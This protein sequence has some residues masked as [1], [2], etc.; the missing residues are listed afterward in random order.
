VKNFLKISFIL[1]FCSINI[2][3]Q[4]GSIG[5]YDARSVGMGK[6]HTAISRGVFSI[7]YN[8]A[9]LAYGENNYLE[10]STLLPLPNIN[11][12]LGTDFITI[13][14]YNYFFGGV[15]DASGNTVGRYLTQAD[16]DRLFSI[17]E[18]GGSFL[19]NFSTSL[20]TASY[21]VNDEI[22]SF[23][24]S[25]CDLISM[26]VNFPEQLVE[27][28]LTGNPNGK[29]Y[30]F[31]DADAAGW[32]LRNYSFSYARSIPDINLNIFE[33]V[34]AGITIKYVQGFAYLGIDKIETSLE[35]NMF[36]EINAHGNILAY[37]S[38]ADDFNVKYDFDSLKT[39]KEGNFALF[40]SPAGKGLGIDLGLSAQLNNVWSFGFAITD[41]GSISWTK[42]VAKYSSNSAIVLRDITDKEETDSLKDAITG[43]GEYVNNFSTSLPTA[44]RMG[45]AFQL[46]KYLDGNFP[47]TM[48]IGFDYNQGFNDQPGNST[49]P[50]FSIGAEWKPMDWIPFIRT[51]FSFGGVD[52]FG[53]A[54]GIGINAGI[55]KLDFATRDFHYLF[56]PNQ[57][58]RI[59]LAFDSKWDF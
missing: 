31:N 39:D 57:A 59:S 17:F 30:N 37:S 58:K 24:F 55:L 19:T 14:D 34:N 33:K 11:V 36:N 56:M 49:V 35:T 40:P 28:A 9:N 4:T 51:G 20:L 27:L 13:K 45:A 29:V 3:P 12:R 10:F 48:L 2:F 43:K 22:G 1:S 8:P 23:G 53:W 41:I 54:F 21:K 26:K 16:K 15:T 47:G 52:M 42:N 7:G 32:W 18:G 46:D 50:R 38:F 6:T 5:A 25:I 44:L